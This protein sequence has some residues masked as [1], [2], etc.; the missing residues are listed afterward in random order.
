MKRGGSSYVKRKT[1]PKKITKYR[2]KIPRELSS[3]RI[4][5]V[6]RHS[7]WGTFTC[8]NTAFAG[9]GMN[10][11]LSQVPGFAELTA[12]YDQYKICGVKVIFLP[13]FTEKSTISVVDQPNCSARFLSVIDYS[14]F[15][16][17]ANMDELRQYETCKMTPIHEKHTRYI[18]GPKYTN[19][20]S[21]QIVSD[22]VNTATPTTQ[23][24][25]LKVGTDAMNSTGILS[26]NYNVEAIYYLCFKNIK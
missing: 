18:P 3:D 24:F 21:G 5:Y 22:W 25:G 16:G 12:M 10:F 17:P 26:F 7:N 9:V 20:G 1:P 15:S 4:H 8:S 14:D 13:P 11:A 2:S 6:K 19:V 23:W